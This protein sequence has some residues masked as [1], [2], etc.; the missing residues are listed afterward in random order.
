[1][2]VKICGITSAAA[3]E[4][5]VAAGVDAVG[6]VFAESPRKL[7]PAQA[8]E[9]AEAVPVGIE[10]VAVMRHPD[11]ALCDEVF[12]VFGPDCLQTDA[13]DFGAIRLPAGCAAL[14]VFRN[15]RV[16]AD[17]AMHERIL[18]EGLVSGSGRTAD[19][20]EAR[21]LAAETRVILAGGLGP[22]NV[23]QAI[24]AVRPFG[25]D[26]SSGV[27]TAPGIKDPVKIRAFVARARAMEN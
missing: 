10:R 4:A 7:S 6:F 11:R 19:W 23:Q 2:F 20:D 21:R 5:A 1:M 8:R 24:Q 3:V 12:E 14:P 22:E 25:V 17:A 27:E 15:G 9:L 26:V 13:E 18:F 16:P